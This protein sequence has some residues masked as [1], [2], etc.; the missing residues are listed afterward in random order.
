MLSDTLRTDI[1]IERESVQGSG[2][3]ELYDEFLDL[4][5]EDL[6]VLEDL[7][8]SV[9]AAMNA[10]MGFVVDHYESAAEEALE[11]AGVY[12]MSVHSGF[13]DLFE[14]SMVEVLRDSVTI[15]KRDFIIKAVRRVV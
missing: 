2:S 10:V 14:G 11:T 9:D 4:R 12:N 8:E 7:T 6:A 3:F 1:V 13:R 5:L 15:S